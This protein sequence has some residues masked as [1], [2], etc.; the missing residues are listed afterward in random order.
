MV[1]PAAPRFR[2]FAEFWPYYLGEH[3]KPMTRAL[4]FAGTNGAL[5]LAA[6][7]LQTHKPWVLLPALGVAYAFAW[8]GHFAVEKNRPATFSYPIWSFMGDWKMW[9]LTWTGRLQGE[10]DRLDAAE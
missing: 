9:A 4:H 6:V 1:D 7:A 3:R 8:I 2:S 10:L 5:A